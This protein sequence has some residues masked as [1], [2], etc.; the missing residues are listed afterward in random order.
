MSFFGKGSSRR[1]L[2]VSCK[3]RYW[4]V[5]NSNIQVLHKNQHFHLLKW[6]VLWTCTHHPLDA[7]HP[8]HK[9]YIFSMATEGYHVQH[10]SHE[11]VWNLELAFLSN[12]LFLSPKLVQF[13]SFVMNQTQTYEGSSFYVGWMRGQIWQQSSLTKFEGA[14][15]SYTFEINIHGWINGCSFWMNEK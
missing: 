8:L 5:Q 3:F 10:K 15:N 6:Q 11:I 4:F 7:H 12:L 14:V 9:E 13:A 2:V 1:C